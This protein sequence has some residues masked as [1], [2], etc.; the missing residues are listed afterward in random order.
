M[1]AFQLKINVNILCT[2]SR[3]FRDKITVSDICY[4]CSGSQT[5]THLF[6]EYDFSKVIWINFTSW[7]NCTN[8][9]QINLQRPD[10][11]FAFHLGKPPFLGINYCL[12]VARNYIYI[13]AK[14]EDPFCFTSYFKFLKIR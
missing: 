7:W 5:L 10:I 14:N 4:L 9:M 12:P 1:S 2:K 11:L 6:V 8:H 13:S 3:L